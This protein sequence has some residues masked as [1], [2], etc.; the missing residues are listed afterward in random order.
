MSL[1]R[2]PVE[3]HLNPYTIGLIKA[4][5]KIEVKKRCKVP[6]FIGKYQDEVYCDVVDR[7]ACQLLFG[8]PW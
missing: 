8:R 2:L 5:E 7:D 3:K 1:L 6:F 4:A